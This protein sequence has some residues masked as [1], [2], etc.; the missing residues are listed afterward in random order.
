MSGIQGTRR[1]IFLNNGEHHH[2]ACQGCGKVV[3]CE[4]RYPD[5]KWCFGG[6]CETCLCGDEDH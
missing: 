4:G 1:P 5:G 2:H 6:Y 3:G